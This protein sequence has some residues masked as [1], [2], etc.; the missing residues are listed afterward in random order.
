MAAIRAADLIARKWASVTPVRVSDYEAGVRSPRTDWARETIAAEQAWA[1]GVTA[2][3]AAKSFPKGVARVGTPGWQKGAIE[4]GT[5]RWGPGVQIAESDY[6]KGFSP[7]RQ[8]IAG[9][10]LPPRFARRDPRN[11]LRVSAIVDAM[12]ATKKS[13]MAA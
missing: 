7:Y 12:N 3:V 13:L 11:L 8:A 1:A 4:K 10:T 2:A 9:V 5:Q 6:L